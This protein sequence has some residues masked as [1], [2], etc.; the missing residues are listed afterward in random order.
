MKLL[1]ARVAVVTGGARGIGRAI[2]EELVREGAQIIIAD[3]GAS[4]DGAEADPGVVESAAAALGA[5]GFAEDVA[6]PGAA[7]KLAKLALDRFGSVDILVNNA[8][9][10][11]DALVF[12]GRRDDFERVIATNLT[13]GFALLAA[14]TP[15][16]RDQAKR[17]RPPGR[18]VNIV[19]SAGLIGNFGQSAYAASKAGLFA[20]TRVAAMDMARSKVACNAVAPF[21]ATRVTESI[22][23]ANEEQAQYKSRALKISPKYVARLTAF[24]VSNQHDITG[25]LF[26]VRGRELFVFTQPRPAAQAELPA[27]AAG[28]GSSLGRIIERELAGAFA[29]LRTDLEIFNTEPLI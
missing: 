18:I 16:M 25:Q 6:A 4:I 3:N 14:L 19:S 9:I 8:A 22:Q 23:P 7:E 26:G 29:D 21:A 13:A 5:V 27:D 15:V 28:N 11:R 24:L 10:L 1:E 20:L 12:K 17:G 2:A